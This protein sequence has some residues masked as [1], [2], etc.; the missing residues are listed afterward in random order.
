MNVLI[1]NGNGTSATSVKQTYLTLKSLLGH[2]YDIMKVDANV[3]KT[4]PWEESCSLLVI[5]GG[6]DIP[7]CEDLN[8]I[9]NNK[10]R[11]YV[12]GGGRYVG[13]CAGAY[14][15]SKEIEFQKGTAIEVTGPR[16]LGFFP[17]KCLG[18]MFPGFV[19]NSERGARSISILDKI[20]GKTLKAYYN[21][22]GYFAHADRWSDKVKVICTYQDP[23][24]S[25]EEKETAAGVYCQ[26]GKGCA[27]LFGFHPEFN[28]QSI[29]LN[30]ND[31]KEEIVKELT[32]SLPLCQ[33]LL[34]QSLALMGLN[35]MK[36]DVLTL[37][38]TPLYLSTISRNLMQTLINSLSKEVDSHSIL[39]DTND[40]FHIAPISQ[41]GRLERSLNKLSIQSE[42]E[43]EEDDRSS[44]FKLFYPSLTEAESFQMPEKSL[45][46][47][48]D[49]KS[50]FESL[51]K[52]RKEEWGGGAWYR[53]GNAVLCSEVITSTQTILDKNY[54]FTQCLPDGLV[55]LATNQI[56]GR[57]RG[58]NSWVSQADALQFSFMI[59]HSLNLK[60]APVVFIQYII[61]LAIVDS[62]RN[63]PGYE[64]IPLRLKWPNDIYADLP[65]G[66]KKVGGLLVNSSFVQD[67]FSLVIGCGINLNNRY[68]T[69]SI[70]D[71]IQDHNP[72]LKRLEK[73]DVL[74]HVLITF[75][76]YYMEF[77]Q[78]GMG[79]WF[80][81]KYYERWLHSGK[82]VT[83]TT[84]NDEKVRIVGITSD[85]G[86]LEAVSVENPRKRF[87]LQPDGNSFDM[88]KGLIIKK[89]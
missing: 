33:A 58:R 38:L 27:L 46:P 45:T 63:R 72:K 28:I 75:E 55:C 34:T 4:E 69:V 8:G 19:Y 41:I 60:N 57:G 54:K 80:L 83:L 12:N 85:Y 68:P 26:V 36:Q 40:S 14:Y 21:G 31:K 82:L 24:L 51:I 79:K 74:A 61:A 17:G 65:S 86:M 6:R 48:F 23:G 77:C 88:L 9:A 53:F 49:L 37:E 42:S 22:G 59:R 32:D 73:E 43:E 7:Y 39:A 29:D 87:T 66:L 18:T 47:S 64:N 81:D 78:K 62:I 35:T 44:V 1:Y 52:R 76:K 11:N 89:A 20:N 3:L 13:F 2:A 16:E 10:I 70:N 25:K 71:I 67:E 15:A 5:P 56:A 84:H 50:F 30:D